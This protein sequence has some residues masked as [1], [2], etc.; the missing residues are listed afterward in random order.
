MKRNWSQ[1]FANTLSSATSYLAAYSG[2]K[3]ARTQYNLGPA[4]NAPN[5]MAR[6]TR[7]RRR[8]RTRTRFIR[9]RRARFRRGTIRHRIRRIWSFMRRQGLRNSETKYIQATFASGTAVASSTRITVLS[10]PDS[11]SA[12]LC[13]SQGIAAGT[14][15][16]QRIGQKVL[17][18]KLRIRFFFTAP[19]KDDSGEVFVPQENHIRFMIVREKEALGAVVGDTNPS[20]YHI[21]QNVIGSDTQ[22]PTTPQA[23]DSR[24]QFISLYKYYSSKFADNYTVLLDRTIKVANEDGGDRY[25][26]MFKYNINIMQPC[27][28]DHVGNRGDGHIYLFWFCDITSVNETAGHIPLAHMSYR[29]T[30]ADC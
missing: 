21:F 17:L 1:A 20:L 24:L 15:Q 23:G 6:T 22:S 29:L 10:N 13:L 18:K 28:W 8:L 2:L 25:Y 26:R 27:L 19:P 16:Q 14:G 7:F 4:R 5:S 3:K 11:L 9:K 12:K 30:F